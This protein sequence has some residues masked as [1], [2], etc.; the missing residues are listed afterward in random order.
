[1]GSSALVRPVPDAECGGVASTESRRP[2]ETAP[3]EH[4]PA[5]QRRLYV[6]NLKVLL[7]GGII[8]GHAVAGYA[9]FE[10]WPYAEMKEV[11]LSP[12]TQALLLALVAPATL[13]LIPLLFLVAGLFA[14]LSLARKGPAAYA[15]SRLLR[16]GLPFVAY[17]LLVQPL[18]MYPV[19]PP[20]E[21]P[22]SYWDELIGGGEQTLDTGPMWFVG[23]LLILS[24][25]YAGVVRARRGNAPR[26][27]RAEL[28]VGHLVLL[29]GAVAVATFLVRLWVPL[30]TSN[31]FVSLNLWE[32]PACAALFAIGIRA[33]EDGW[34]T[35]VPDRMHRRS[36]GAA[37]I[38]LGGFAMFAVVAEAIGVT[39]EQLWGGPY[40]SAL[41]F[42]GL[43]SVLAVF[44]PVWLV[45]AA[46][47]HLDRPLRWAGPAVRRGAYAAFMLQVVPLIGLAVALRPLPLAAELKAI[48]LAGSAIVSSFA[49][50]WLLIRRV[51]GAARIL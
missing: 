43:E 27:P 16:L 29:A 9:D 39:E 35:G 2:S 34:L 47:R 11:T 7:I 14:P 17:V 26:L 48:L 37:L 41:V 10:F 33:G 49:L 5:A 38:A 12:V 21:E 8:V 42:A 51:P 22:D 32:W 13:V 31:R 18:L 50:A 6:D 23:V 15:R 46:Q 40:W 28:S 4:V 30:G 3:R 25:A 19:H 20:G 36:R 1:M 24:L 44:G 45:A